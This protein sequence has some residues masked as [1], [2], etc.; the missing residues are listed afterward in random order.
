MSG[1]GLSWIP[2]AQS[3]TAGLAVLAFAVPPQAA[4]FVFAFSPVIPLP[5]QA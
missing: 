4:S 5:P 2:S 3:P 1:L